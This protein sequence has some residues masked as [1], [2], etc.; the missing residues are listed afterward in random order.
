MGKEKEY[1]KL[2]NSSIIKKRLFFLFLSTINL[3]KPI[4]KKFLNYFTS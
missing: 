1:T 4:M 3:K 2:N